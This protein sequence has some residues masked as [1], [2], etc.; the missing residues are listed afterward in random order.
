MLGKKGR[1]CTSFFFN[2][3]HTISDVVVLDPQNLAGNYTTFF[4]AK[5]LKPFTTGFGTFTTR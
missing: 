1:H 2:F 3:Y 5:N 4:A